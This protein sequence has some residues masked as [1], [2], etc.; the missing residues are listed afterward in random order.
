MGCIE[1]KWNGVAW[2]Y[3]NVIKR[4][5]LER[6]FDRLRG[7]SEENK[8]SWAFDMGAVGKVLDDQLVDLCILPFSNTTLFVYFTYFD[9]TN[10]KL[11]EY[12]L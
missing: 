8:K 11:E 12:I 3:T 9:E 2:T 5:K 7:E 6:D 10:L 1:A 4:L